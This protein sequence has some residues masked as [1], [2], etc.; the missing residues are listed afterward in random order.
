MGRAAGSLES[1]ASSHGAQSAKPSERAALL[2]AAL[3]EDYIPA[4]L[5]SCEPRVALQCEHGGSEAVS[6]VL[7]QP[8]M[9]SV[10]SCYLHFNAV[11][12]GKKANLATFETSSS[13][14][15]VRFPPTSRRTRPA[16]RPCLGNCSD[17]GGSEELAAGPPVA[18]R[19]GRAGCP[20]GAMCKRSRPG[21][22]WSASQGG[23]VFLH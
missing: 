13:A 16:S 12:S 17:L 23:S 19:R 22:S 10:E 18:D 5:R 20:E 9:A 2:R 7:Q 1:G 21:C 8:D 14:P 11:Y 4:L 3:S 15:C 6:E